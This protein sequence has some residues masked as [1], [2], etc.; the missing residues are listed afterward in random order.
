[1]AALIALTSPP[2][3]NS[4]IFLVMQIHFCLWRLILRG[5]FICIP[6][7]LLSNSRPNKRQRGL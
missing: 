7:V 5:D 6:S 3:A 2:G 1:M 4:S